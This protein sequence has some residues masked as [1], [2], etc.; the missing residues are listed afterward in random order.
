[1]YELATEVCV[2][3]RRKDERDDCVYVHNRRL[4]DLGRLGERIVELFSHSRSVLEA[5]ENSDHRSESQSHGKR[6]DETERP[7]HTWTSE[8]DT[9]APLDEGLQ[10]DTAH[11]DDV[12][13]CLEGAVEEQRTERLA[14]H[15]HPLWTCLREIRRE[16]TVEI[17]I[18]HDG[19]C[20]E[21]E[22]DPKKRLECDHTT[23]AFK[24]ADSLLASASVLG[25]IVVG[26]RLRCDIEACLVLEDGVAALVA[27]WRVV[28]AVTD[29]SVNKDRK[30]KRAKRTSPFGS[31]GHLACK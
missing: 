17:A 20:K 23:N 11:K 4:P 10:G 13:V 7:A 14:E 25:L 6:K 8:S 1:M 18:G 19:G 3:V 16:G 22:K 30:R 26:E 2:G 21:T 9:V 31:V 5:V 24:I 27:L 12:H 29:S 28:L 15:V